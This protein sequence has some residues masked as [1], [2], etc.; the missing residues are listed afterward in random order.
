MLFQIAEQIINFCSKGWNDILRLMFPKLK[1]PNSWF[2]GWNSIFR[3]DKYRI[4]CFGAERLCSGVDIYA[5]P[6]S[7][8]V[9]L[10]AQ[11]QNILVFWGSCLRVGFL[12]QNWQNF[13]SCEN[14]SSLGWMCYHNYVSLL[15]PD[16]TKTKL[17]IIFFTNS[18]AME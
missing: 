7:E 3:T 14:L 9:G 11:P 4:S 1:W 16:L 5:E 12:V 18:I 17:A 6:T 10:T 13:C 2:I 15:A 8:L